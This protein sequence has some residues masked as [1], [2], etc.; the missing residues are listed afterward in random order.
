MSEI[1]Q[2]APL[3]GYP[4]ELGR[5]LWAMQTTRNRTLE[6]V[7]GLNQVTLDWEGPD[8]LDN[9]IGTLLYHIALAEMA[10]LYLDILEGTFPP[11]VKNDFP[12]EMVDSQKEIT[13]VANVT[14]EEHLGRLARSRSLF[15]NAFHHITLDDWRR[16]RSPEDVEY[17]VTPEWAVFHLVEHEAGHAFQISSLKRRANRFLR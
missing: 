1:L 10:W 4:D 3:Q 15:L 13:R 16:L 11:E 9:S 6:L 17:E 2:V 12:F 7:E 14:L 5:W 8:G